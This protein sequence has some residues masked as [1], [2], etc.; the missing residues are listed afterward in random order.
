MVIEE[1]KSLKRLN[2][3][4]IEAAAKYF[5]AFSSVDELAELLEFSKRQANNSQRPPLILGGGSN[6]LFTGDY[7]GLVLKNEIK[8]IKTIHEDEHHVYVQVG[9]G[10][11]WHGF[12]THCIRHN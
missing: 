11:N 12:V 4:G 8:G 9:A 6:I 10:E 3:F 5:A 7:N 2:T 1:A